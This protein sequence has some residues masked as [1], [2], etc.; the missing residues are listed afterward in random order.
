MGTNSRKLIIGLVSLAVVLAVFLLYNLMSETPPIDIDKGAELAKQIADSNAAEFDR[1]VGK[2][3]DVG[4]G[5][6]RK[7]KYT[8]LNAQKQ[9]DREFGFEKLLHEEADQWEIEKPYMNI[10]RRNFKCY[11]TADKGTVQIEDA[12]GRATPKDA[13]LTGNVVIHILP[14]AA[15]GVK[16]SFVYLDD[17]VY[18]SERSQFSTG[19]PVKFVSADAQMLGTGMEFV[20]ND[21][22]NR[23]EFLRIIQLEDLRIRTSSQASLLGSQQTEPPAKSV[24]GDVTQEQAAE[25]NAK[26]AERESRVHYRCLFDKNV[27]VNAPQQ[28]VLTDRLSIN[29]ILLSKAS[30]GKSA[31]ADETPPETSGTLTRAAD[32]STEEFVDITVTC[33][34][35]ILVTPMDSPAAPESSVKVET[36]PALTDNQV[37]E[38]PNDTTDRTKFVAQ[39]IDYCAAVGDT[40]ASGPSELTF[41]VNDLI[42]RRAPQAPVPVKV[43]AQKQAQFQ[44]A[45]NQ[46]VFEGD[47]VC[48]MTRTDPNI[49]QEYSLAAPK[50]MVNLAEDKTRQS[51]GPAA[52]IEHVTADGGVVQLAVV[53]ETEEEELLGFTKLKCRRFDYDSS[54]QMC[55]ATGPDGLIAAD[56]SKIQEPREKVSKFGLRRQCYAVVRGFDTMKYHLETNQI[57]A[58]AEKQGIIIDYFPIVKGQQGPQTTVTTSHIEAPLYETDTGRIELASL[59][60]TGGFTYE[61]KDIEFQGSRAFYDA[62]KSLITAQGDNVQPCYLNGALADA[63]EYNLRTGKV[64]TKITGPGILRW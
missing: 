52:A 59:S 57:I 58:D 26:V 15:T 4:V 44:P 18:I 2:I 50:I 55:V 7:A 30:S 10:F 22:L 38:S 5:T 28:T 17:V 53:K 39:R 62:G 32:E 16:E 37:T 12:L 13:T 6:V 35:G 42:D 33:D 3:A 49:R 48:T 9:L 40:I 56:N 64:K 19:G 46:V 1:E 23:L 61:E 27:V 29:N 63:I 36:R 41:Y 20:Y 60:A 43:T 21:E 31:K 54:E 45:A 25:G 47:C 8:H 24:A 34:G 14:E 51:G 11:I